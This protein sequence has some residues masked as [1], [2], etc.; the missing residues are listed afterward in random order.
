M[1]F[2][3]IFH[4]AIKFVSFNKTRMTTIKSLLVTK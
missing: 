4:F 1:R 2:T 3:V